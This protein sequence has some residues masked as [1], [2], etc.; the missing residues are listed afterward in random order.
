MPPRK[1]PPAPVGPPLF[2]LEPAPLFELEPAPL[3]ELEPAPV[4]SLPG[5]VPVLAE[6]A[7]ENRAARFAEVKKN[8][9]RML[10]CF[11]VRSGVLGR[12]CR[13]C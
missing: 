13:R 7:N 8:P 10:V 4:P 9:C 3:F 6:Q 2:E 5:P 1:E 11:L 12:R